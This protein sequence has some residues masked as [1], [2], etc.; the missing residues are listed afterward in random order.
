MKGLRPVD[1]SA[2]AAGASGFV[3]ALPIAALVKDL[4]GRVLHANGEFLRNFGVTLSEVTGR[5][6][7][8]LFEPDAAEGLSDGNELALAGKAACFEWSAETP[9]GERT[10][11]VRTMPADLAPWGPVLVALFEDITEQKRVEVA[12]ARERDFTRVV[13]DTTDALILVLDLEG[14]IERWNQ[15]CQTVTGYHESEVRGRVF[16]EMLVAEADQPAI[17]AHLAE[18]AQGNSGQRGELRLWRRAGG[19]RLVAWS[20]ALL[21]SDEGEPA[22]IIITALDQTPQEHAQREKQQTAME[23]RLVW[24][25]AADAMAFLDEDGRVQAANPSFCTLVSLDR[26]AVE[27]RLLVEVMRQWPG[28]EEEEARK[29]RCAFR[30]RSL[31]ARS[32]NEYHL[33]G[34]ARVWLES[35]NSYLERAGHAPLV[36]LVLR[37]ITERVRQEQELKSTNEF[38]ATTTEWAREMAASAELASAAKS[39]FLANVS[40]EIRTPMNGILGMTE[41]TLMTPLTSEQREY[42]SMVQSSAESLLGLLDEIL[43]LSKAEAGWMELRCASFDLRDLL[44]QAI[45]P[46]MHRAQARGL[47][48]S[49]LVGDEAPRH[50]F[51]DAGRLRQVIINLVGNAIKFTDHGQIRVQVSAAPAGDGRARVRFLVRDTGIG[52]DP[53]KLQSIFEPFTQ[54]DGSSTRK[55]GGTGLGLSISAR[56]VELMGSRLYV[57]SAPGEGATFAFTLSLPLGEPPAGP[58]TAQPAPPAVKPATLAAGGRPLRC[59]IAEDNPVNQLLV[60]RMLE[61]AGHSVTVAATGREV[62]EHARRGNFDLILMDIQMPDMDGLEAAAALR[63]DE[64]LSGGHIPIVAMTAHAMASDRESCLRAGMDGYLSKPLRMENLLREIDRVMRLGETRENPMSSLNI[65][66]ALARLGGDAELLSELAGLFAGQLP[67]LLGEAER[68]LQGLDITAGIAPAHT[69]KGLLA[70]FG[71]EQA[72]ELA[73]NL[74]MAAR[75]NRRDEALALLAQLK[76]SCAA[77][78]PALERVASG[79]LGEDRRRE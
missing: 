72:N 19:S 57:T 29:Y 6:D 75:E 77:I 9:G 17:R 21:R 24:D 61:V 28:H 56:L 35:T 78:L 79:D 71:A 30:E 68:G 47:E 59:L 1:P 49:C 25:N 46:L 45:R 48:L 3:D 69:L 73:R 26:E 44:H 36:L 8:E 52:M 16:W 43:D 18:V 37:N 5:T 74:E 58:G 65:G 12:L 55:R 11:L 33:A 54:L 53:G 2:P 20:A 14:R 62:V 38:L 27:G 66:A 39:E 32:V 70:Q 22:F 63:S 40:H 10:L 7:R 67:E 76:H 15:V 34:G 64:L 50:L 51:G 41:L 13:L 42:L 60:V 4:D 31:P 23:F